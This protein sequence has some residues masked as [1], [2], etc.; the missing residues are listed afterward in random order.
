MLR[1]I[2]SWIA[3][4]LC[5]SS[6]P[7]QDA[8]NKYLTIINADCESNDAYHF[9][10]START[11]ITRIGHLVKLSFPSAKKELKSDIS[12]CNPENPD[13]KDA[14]VAVIERVF[15]EGGSD[16]EIELSG[17]VS[18]QNKAILQEALASLDENADVEAE[19]VIYDYDHHAR[20]H[21]KRL[22]TFKKPIKLVIKQDRR[23]Q[24]SEEPDTYKVKNPMNF[25][26]EITLK[27][28]SGVEDQKMG[29]AFRSSGTQ[30]TRQLSS[31]L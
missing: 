6:L 4:L 22:H 21:F 20:K 23:A 7:A 25:I 9:D 5:F 10:A 11:S 3:T 31:P 18:A 16:D 19:F 12:V 28:K 30:F 1:K 24:I 13:V 29:F 15:W 14:I 17:R 26:F 2:T 27:P 8:P